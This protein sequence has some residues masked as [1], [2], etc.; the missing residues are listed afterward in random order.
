MSAVVG[1]RAESSIGVARYCE[2]LAAALQ[3]S[4]VEYVL[5]DRPRRGVPG[6]WHLANSSRS[7]A[8]QAAG[9]RTP[10]LVT[11]HDVVP[12]TTALLPLYRLVVFP[13]VRQA[14]AVIVHSRYAADLLMAH[15]R[16]SPER[17]SILPHPAASPTAT[18]RAAARRALGWPD[19]AL[20]AVL[21]G[22]IKPAKLV[23][24][25]VAAAA[26]L[27]Q[28][29]RWR[30]ALAG[31]VHDPAAAREAREVGAWVLPSPDAETYE[32]AIVAA[33]A[34]LV[35]R[36][37]SVGE[38]NGPLLDAIGAGRA[39][40]ATATGSIPEAAGGAAILCA[41]DADAIRR[42]LERL[43]DPEERSERER[44]AAARGAELT[45]D[46]SAEAH[47][48]LYAEVFGG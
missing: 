34:V 17:I 42:G 26:P 4:G 23:R 20:V 27:L 1:I 25:A 2:R 46:V 24:E 35:L 15:A 18:N 48:R 10:F 22:V 8:W 32:R 38:T 9:R 41:P 14:A 45:W 13:V 12:R 3:A 30:L 16:V 19:D 33:D 28:V 47:V 7:A 5:A 37:A 39:V 29:G 44:L 40:L 36:S 11:V 6:H 31:H 43:T 21:P